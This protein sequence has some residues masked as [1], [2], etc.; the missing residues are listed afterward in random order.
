M[1]K[2]IIIATL[3][4]FFPFAAQAFKI[5]GA[6]ALPGAPEKKAASEAPKESAEDSQEALVSQF[7]ETLGSMLL[8][9][10]YLAMAFDQAD[11]ASE[12]ETEITS[13]EGDCGTDCLK[14]IV[15]V[16]GNANKSIGKKLEAKTEIN[17]SGK[18]NYL[19]AFPPYMKGTL[20]IKDLSST[21]ADWGKQAT[22]EVKSAGMM[23]APKLKKKLDAGLYVAQQTPKLLKSWAK[24]TKQIVTYAKASNI[25]LGSVKGASDFDFGD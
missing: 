22:G 20:S 3:L 2:I 4:S 12:L 15:K 10:K 18:A 13:L 21:A 9:Q 5:P 17:S 25:D 19:L 24:A 8:A 1:K 23:N 16:S 7:K 14:R 6:G 11:Q